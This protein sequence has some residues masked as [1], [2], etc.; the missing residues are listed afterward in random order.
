[1]SLGVG[2]PSL[3]RLIFEGFRTIRSCRR[4]RWGRLY[5]PYIGCEYSVGAGAFL[6]SIGADDSEQKRG[7]GSDPG[8]LG[9]LVR[10]K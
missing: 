9:I 10:A 5:Q 2:C 4:D 7:K 6:I 3:K 8:Q 1:M